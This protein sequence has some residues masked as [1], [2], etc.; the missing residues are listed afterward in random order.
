MTNTEH[1][2]KILSRFSVEPI[3]FPNPSAKGVGVFIGRERIGMAM[4]VDGGYLVK[5]RR[6]P[7]QFLHQAVKQMID[8]K[9]QAAKKLDE[10]AR[11]LMQIL[12]DTI[13]TIPSKP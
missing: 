5:Q 1:D 7:V 10:E 8:D 2:E 12:R 13:G 9:H 11:K 3:S 6:K 4:I